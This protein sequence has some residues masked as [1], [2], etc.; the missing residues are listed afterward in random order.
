[1]IKH[2][3]T[4][5]KQILAVVSMLLLVVFLA[6]TLV[7]RCGGPQASSGTVYASLSDGSKLTLGELAEMRGQ[8][9]VLAMMQEPLTR[10]LGV[11]KDPEHWWL[12]VREAR[13]AGLVGGQSDARTVLAA[14]AAQRG[15]TADQ[16]LGQ[17]AS[18]ARQPGPVVLDALANLNGV[19]RLVTLAIGGRALSDARARTVA[20]ELL[21]SVDCET[22]MIDAAT[23]G[24]RV[25]V[26]PPTADRIAATFE[27]GKSKLAGAGPGGIGYRWPERVR[28]EWMTVS[29]G[30]IARSL[31][32]DPALGAVELRKEFR[33]DPAKFGVPAA[34][35]APGATPP[36]FDAYAAKVRADVERRL[37]AERA[38]RIASFVRDWV[39][40][41][42]KDLPSEGGLFKLPEDWSNRPVTLA[43]LS[44]ELATRFGVAA[45]AVTGPAPALVPVADLAADPVLSRATV[46]E[47]GKPMAVA[48]ALRAMRPIDP[49]SRLPMQPGVVGPVARTPTDDVVVWRVVEADPA[50]DPASLDEVRDAVVKDTV[51]EMR[52]DRLA[53]M[54]GEIQ[55][56]AAA[57]GLA[58]VAKDYGGTLE[59]A[60]NVHLADPN[61]MRTYGLRFPST[62]ARAGQD[63]DAIRAVVRR[64][65]ALPTDR[66]A[67]T[68]PAADRT[69]AVAVPAKLG[70]IVANISKVTPITLE[71]YQALAAQGSIAQGSMQD[72]PKPDLPALFG[73]DA[74]KKRAG[75]ALA[76]PDGPDRVIAEP[77]PQF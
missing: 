37:V 64:A 55:A 73:S 74:M 9:A 77:A 8:L 27:K 43:A 60:T 18:S 42:T 16:L 56:R 26:D 23:V 46:S 45:P 4:Y 62:L 22:V 35:L 69:V 41:S 52:Y 54:V 49:E 72:E 25:P 29:S 28:M 7:T 21:T 68:L 13:A 40:A 10:Q 61:V 20:R 31:A 5:N 19:Q 39:R 2:L 36:S 76:N 1:M 14:A 70:V 24:D 59:R 38:E 33:K 57:D 66:P 53:A 6:P 12:L 34:E 47:F 48:A 50:H 58:D 44:Q 11:E 30:D 15:M 67:D 17:V 65:V 71:D 63:V 51:T 75:F 32:G 3:Q